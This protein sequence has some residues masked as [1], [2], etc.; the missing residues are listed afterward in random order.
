[1]PTPQRVESETSKQVGVGEKKALRVQ[2]VRLV[3]YELSTAAFAQ[4]DLS[5]F[6]VKSIRKMGKKG[7]GVNSKVAA[8]KERQEQVASAKAAK[9]RA[10]EEAA[11]AKEWSKGSNQKGAKKE[12]EA[13]RKQEEKMA[14]LAAKKAAEREDAKDLSGYK[15]VV[16]SRPSHAGSCLPLSPPPSPFS[17]RG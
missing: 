10:A 12:E 16:V 17:M 3:A 11:A 2:G 6:T 5:W 9:A 14:K 7:S 15:S 4:V 13:A 1:M 8:A